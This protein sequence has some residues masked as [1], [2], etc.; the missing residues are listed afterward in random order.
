[1]L[2]FILFIEE[3]FRT[4]SAAEMMAALHEGAIIAKYP[5]ADDTSQQSLFL[6]SLF[7]AIT[8][9]FFFILVSHPAN[10]LIPIKNI[11]GNYNRI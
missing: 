1:M 4:K 10:F 9:W 3:I 11:E 2:I 7:A 5:V 6:S 8:L